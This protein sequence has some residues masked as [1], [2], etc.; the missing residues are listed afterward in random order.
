VFAPTLRGYRKAWLSADLVAG[1]TVGAMLVPQAM[2]YA[3]LAGLPPSVGFQAALV[4]LVVYSLVGGSRH[5]GVGPEPGTAVL[6]AAGVGLVAGGDPSTYIA[7]MAALALLVGVIAL[8]AGF[9]KLSA[10]A[11]LLSKPVLV[12]YITGV[13]L[14]LLSSQLGKATGVAVAGDDFFGRVISFFEGIANTRGPV[15][16]VFL[17]TLLL[18]FGLKRFAPRLPGALISVLLATLAV[19]LVDLEVPRV[20]AVAALNLAPTLPEVTLDDVL[21]LVPT[22]LGIALVGYTD[23][24]LTAR[25]VAGRHGYKIE[26]QREL[27]ALSATNV[28]AGLFGGFPVSS[29]ASRTAIPSSLGSHSQLTG[30]VAALFLVLA[31]TLAPGVLGA[32][33]TA[34][35]AA[36]IVSAAFAIIDVEGYR[37]L[38]HLSRAEVALAVVAALAVMVFDVLVGVLIA[39]V[40]SV[41]L[42]IRRLSRPH[43]TTLA[44][45]PSRGGWVDARHY[46]LPPSIHGLLVYRFDAPLFFANI[47]RFRQ[48]LTESLH[49][50]PGEER[51][52][53]LDLEGVGEVDA[54]ALEG[55]R[56]L[57]LELKAAGQLV[58]CAR[59][60]PRVIAA[61]ERGQILSAGVLPF[62]T[63]HAAVECFRASHPEFGEV[64]RR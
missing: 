3:E 23:N 52:I 41:A 13:G 36:V 9:L 43:D 8:I 7:L 62:P 58:A 54:T 11:D 25:S 63:I 38:W 57:V 30:L 20:G 45:D 34:A 47:E 51:F 10:L 32:M 31:L 18:I 59:G 21:A 27:F 26:S 40:L 14:T 55:L 48:R 46:G 6:A 5:L 33:P 44:L 12:G 60:N 29:S 1:V 35:L 42:L 4:P 15:L 56:E 28:S 16:V 53:I 61:L 64:P 17:G 2:A 24:I 22:A 19:T 37:R 50:N 39:V 49:E